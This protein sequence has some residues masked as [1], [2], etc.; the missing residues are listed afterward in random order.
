MKNFQLDNFDI[1]DDIIRESVTCEK[2]SKHLV[3]REPRL[4]W[5][6]AHFSAGDFDP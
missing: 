2:C 1:N 6:H 5:I 4:A 3:G